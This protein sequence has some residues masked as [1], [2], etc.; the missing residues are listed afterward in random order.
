MSKSFEPFVPASRTI[1]EFTLR[2]FLLGFLLTVVMAAAN[3]YLGLYA[4]TTVT[5]SIPSAIIAMGVL[6]NLLKRGTILESN[7]VQTMASSGE[8]VAAG[9][10]FTVPALLIAGIW[11]EVDFWSTTLI[12]LSG[13]TLGTVLMIP[14]RRAH[15]VE[16]EHLLY[17]EGRA[18]AEVLKAG[19]TGG[20]R[21]KYVLSA[22]GVGAA[23][24]FLTSGISIFK[25]SIEWAFPVGRTAFF[26]GTDVS[27]ALL[28][29]GY[30]VGLNISML[31]AIGGV[32][33]WWV[34]IPILGLASG[35]QG[36]PL[37]WYWTA[38]SEKIRYLGVGAM[39]V[40]GVASI[41][42]VRKA[43]LSS[44]TETV[45][46][47]RAGKAAREADRT[48]VS[49]SAPTMAVIFTVSL[50]LMAL[51]FTRL[52]LGTGLSI[53]TIALC[54]FLSFFLVAVSSYI[55]GI[56]G[57]SNTPVS[58]M[59][60]TA[61]LIGGALLLVG[62]VT[63]QPGI[64]AT[65]AIAGVICCMVCVSGE[66]SQELK[67][68]YLL[69][70]TPRRQQWA[71]FAGA[72]IACFVMA[73]ILT[74]LQESYGIG[75]GQPGA[76]KAPQATLFASLSRAL[77]GEGSLPWDLVAVGAVL[78]LAI[79]AADRHLQKRGSKIRLPVMAT[80]VGMYLPV[81]L[82]VP[83]VL[84]GLV[85]HFSPS[86]NEDGRGILYSSGL[87]AGEAITGVLLG[88]AIY[89]NRDM[90]PMV[91]LDSNLA[92]LAALAAMAAL[93]YRTARS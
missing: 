33:A 50:V 18:C 78:G 45:S 84:G 29:V 80:A 76:L 69:G 59:T 26:L 48:D 92:S 4:G 91:L 61:V 46:S 39:M 1:A 27:P 85:R 22:M 42:S 52:G 60:I 6:R 20:S 58:G 56:V 55:V 65:L 44:L 11:K 37:D 25:G 81:T 40:G 66:M 38:W 19:E 2:A 5:A 71:Q 93:L 72:I 15:V 87:V 73:P 47:F 49:M 31:M 32:L 67:V 79:L 17:P 10:L 74:V 7:I 24:K 14:L 63:G 68:G 35:V 89:F 16:D 83:M 43:I 53:A 62:G 34:A 28:G 36:S 21:A 64:V 3:L 75:T 57:G 70:A 51:L 90:F 54:I 88:T 12:C 13:A 41:I 9:V 82:A 23:V 77:F 86:E 8:T 30:I